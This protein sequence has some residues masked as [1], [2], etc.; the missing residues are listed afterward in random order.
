MK[1]DLTFG[2]DCRGDYAFFIELTHFINDWEIDE[3]AKI[4]IGLGTHFFRGLIDGEEV[5]QHGW[6]E[7]G[8]VVQWG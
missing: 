5:H 1:Q 7:D 8:K 3:E 6:I 2:E 4:K